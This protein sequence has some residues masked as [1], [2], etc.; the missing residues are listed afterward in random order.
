MAKAKPAHDNALTEHTE[1]IL[2]LSEIGFSGFERLLTLSMALAKTVFD[3]SMANSHTLADMKDI[4]D[5]MN[6]SPLFGTKA[7][8]QLMDYFRGVQQITTD[9][10]EQVLA[11][12]NQ[13]MA[14]FGGNSAV[15][16]PVV[17]MFAKLAAQ[18]VEMTTTNLKTVAESVEAVADVA[19]TE[20]E[21]VAKAKKTA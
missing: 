21:A 4:N 19:D 18:T 13:Q 8:E 17:D 15:A 9:V 10:Q 1:L 14:L 11:I 6:I 5:M 2:S 7:T 20:A 12:M 3:D 16:N